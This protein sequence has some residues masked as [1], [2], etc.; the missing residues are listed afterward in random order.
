MT[1]YS[2][3]KRLREIA[4]LAAEWLEQMQT[5]EGATAIRDMVT[6]A[7]ALAKKEAELIMLENKHKIDMEK[8][9]RTAIAPDVVL[10]F[11]PSGPPYLKGK[12]HYDAVCHINPDTWQ[13]WSSGDGE[14]IH[15]RFYWDA[16]EQTMEFKFNSQG[17]VELGGSLN[18]EGMGKSG[19]RK[20]LAD[21]TPSAIGVTWER[22]QVQIILESYHQGAR[23]VFNLPKEDAEALAR[24]INLRLEEHGHDSR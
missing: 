1:K 4:L 6:R 16:Q 8:G 15:V 20:V 17:A 22:G 21:Y 18:S 12:E 7:D 13:V 2:H 19:D 9:Y 5:K 3:E 23:C 10:S 14:L 24:M 11:E